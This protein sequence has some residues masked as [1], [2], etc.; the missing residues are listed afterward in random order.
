MSAF[1]Q[2]VLREWRSLRREE[3]RLTVLAIIGPL[4]F[5]LVVGAVYSHKKIVGIPATIVDQDSS[6]LSREITRAILA[7]ETFALGQYAASPDEFRRLAAEGR[8]HICF[9]F[10][11][12]FERD[13][14]AGKSAEVAVLVDATNLITGN[15]AVPTASNLLGSYSIGVDIR[16]ME[17]RGQGPDARVAPAA[18]P[19]ALQT[20]S[21]FNPAFNSNYAN[22]LVLGLI[23]IPVQLAPLLAACRA[24]AREFGAGSVELARLSPN[25]GLVAA[26]KCAAYV[27]FL[28]PVC[29]LTLHLP[30]WWLGL[31]M[32]GSEWLVAGLTLWFVTNMTLLGFAISCLTMDALFGSEICA[33]LT[34]PNFLIS[35]F[36]WPAFAMPRGL[37][38]AAYLL[39]MNPFAL[40]LRKV[41]LMGAGAGDLTREI[42]LLSGWSLLTATLALWGAYRLLRSG[43]PGQPEEAHS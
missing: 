30:Q 21:W 39:P 6:A 41:T 37:E 3:S 38:I 43:K 11:R 31:P 16:T 29:W 19:V 22:F 25:P 15:V 33:L 10:P 8:S 13:I 12:H 28:W 4:V 9:V 35:G 5:A 42:A 20:R 7:T 1:G 34:M 2:I 40:A 27:A 32:I 26:A 36:T 17:K 24:G 18:M 23:V 14:K